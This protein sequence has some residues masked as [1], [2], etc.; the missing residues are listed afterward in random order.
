M[1]Y[2][3]GSHVNAAKTPL[4]DPRKDEISSFGDR[5]QLELLA[6]IATL[7]QS[8]LKQT[9]VTAI[10]ADS[11]TIYVKI[12][13]STGVSRSQNYPVIFGLKQQADFG[14]KQA[15]SF[16]TNELIAGQ[17]RATGAVRVGIAVYFL[18]FKSASTSTAN[19]N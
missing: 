5:R 15:P 3:A 18:S 9:Q 8:Q 17:N 10:L 6:A 13:T 14:K 12:H 16:E 11:K 19:Y 2:Q 7:Q 1:L 4:V